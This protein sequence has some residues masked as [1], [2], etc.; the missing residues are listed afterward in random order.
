MGWFSEPIV[1][2]VVV[3]QQTKNEA[4][5]EGKRRYT[6]AAIRLPSSALSETTLPNTCRQSRQQIAENSN[7]LMAG[8]I[9]DTARVLKISPTTAI[10]ALT[11]TKLRIEAQTHPTLAQTQ[12]VLLQG[13][14]QTRSWIEMKCRLCH[15]VATTWLWQMIIMLQN[16]LAYV[17]GKA[18]G[19]GIFLQLKANCCN[20]LDSAFYTLM[21][22]KT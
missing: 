18:W 10:E 1:R 17:L 12:V 20:P 2:I 16:I 4:S 7:K 6:C 5:N 11:S 22:G 14:G 13:A 8:G 21:V 15:P 19:Y 9:R 3:S